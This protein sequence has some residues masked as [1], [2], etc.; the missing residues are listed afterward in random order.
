MTFM[1]LEVR[2]L[3]PGDI[4]R[5]APLFQ[6][7]ERG[8]KFRLGRRPKH[9]LARLEIRDDPLAQPDRN[10]RLAQPR[11]ALERLAGAHGLLLHALLQ[12]QACGATLAARGHQGA[13]R[14][15]LFGSRQRRLKRTGGAQHQ[16]QAGG[17]LEG[18]AVVL[19]NLGFLQAADDVAIAPGLRGGLEHVGW[20]VHA[21]ILPEG[22]GS[23]N[24][25]RGRI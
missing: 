12:L 19:E 25:R 3:K 23:R 17:S 11:E 16:G 4:V 5:Q 2:R 18:R 8:A 21:P 20:A 14:I 15:D 24:W 1:R 9:D 13:K 7:A 10:H 22:P 6:L